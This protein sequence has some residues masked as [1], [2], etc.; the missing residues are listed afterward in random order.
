[1]FLLRS[2]IPGFC[3]PVFPLFLPRVPTNLVA[4]IFCF[5]PCLSLISS[6]SD[7]SGR[8]I[9]CDFSLRDVIFRVVC[10]YA[11]NRNPDSDSL[12]DGPCGSYDSC[13]VFQHCF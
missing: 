11:P 2:V 3:P 6:R 1:M 7:S 5:P 9:A 8:L 12:L 13:W 4:V 10:V